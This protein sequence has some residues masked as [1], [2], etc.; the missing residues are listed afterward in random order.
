MYYRSSRIVFAPGV[1]VKDSNILHSA[2]PFVVDVELFIFNQHLNGFPIHVLRHLLSLSYVR[3]DRSYALF[4][5]DP[6]SQYHPLCVHS[7]QVKHLYLHADVSGLFASR[8]Q[9]ARK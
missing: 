9:G 5:P 3:N 8:S 4:C 1:T 2:D 7:C 6:G